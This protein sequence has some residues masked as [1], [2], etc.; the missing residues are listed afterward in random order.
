MQSGQRGL[1]G[2]APGWVCVSH[3]PGGTL[4]PLVQMAA[5]V[6]HG[7]LGSGGMP[8][9]WEPWPRSS[10]ESGLLEPPSPPQDRSKVSCLSEALGPWDRCL[11]VSLAGWPAVEALTTH[12]LFR[13]VPEAWDCFAWVGEGLFKSGSL[14]PSQ[15]PGLGTS[16]T[17]D[18][19]TDGPVLRSGSCFSLTCPWA[20]SGPYWGSS[21]SGPVVWSRSEALSC[22]PGPLVCP[23]SCHPP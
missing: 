16:A 11:G 10:P 7:V 15:I 4:R 2:A 20:G 13:P 17:R 5:A 19:G 12:C 14:G 9:P 23:W 8:P 6:P 1:Q 21:R 22:S 3:S 18:V